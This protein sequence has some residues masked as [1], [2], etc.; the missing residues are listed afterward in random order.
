MKV[1]IAMQGI[2]NGDTP[3]TVE[4]VT[5][6]VRM[7]WIELD[8]HRFQDVISARFEAGKDEVSSCELIL[9]VIGPVE[10]VYTDGRGVPLSGFPI[11][12]EFPGNLGEVDHQAIVARENVEAR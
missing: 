2:N 9:R 12:V 8:G 1:R 3:G 6:G 5:H 11:E 4:E 10:L 7:P